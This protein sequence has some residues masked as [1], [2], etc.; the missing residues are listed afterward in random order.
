[1]EAEHNRAANGQLPSFRAKRPQDHPVDGGAAK[2]ASAL[3]A[4]G[5]RERRSDKPCGQ[6]SAT[7]RG[8]VERLKMS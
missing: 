8:T 6:R 1:M 3:Q 5:E 2:P 4:C 7:R